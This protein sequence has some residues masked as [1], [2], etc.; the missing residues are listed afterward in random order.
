MGHIKSLILALDSLNTN[1]R[2]KI[3]DQT[4]IAYSRALQNYETR[5]TNVTF[6]AKYN[7]P[8]LGCSLSVSICKSYHICGETESRN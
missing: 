1:D 4:W 3:Q 5:A 7:A 8:I 6:L 2:K